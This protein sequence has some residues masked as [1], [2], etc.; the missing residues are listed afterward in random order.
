MIRRPPRSTLFPYTTLFRSPPPKAARPFASLKRRKAL[1]CSNRSKGR[2]RLDVKAIL[3]ALVLG[4]PL[5][6]RIRAPRRAR[7]LA[8]MSF[9]RTTLREE[10]VSRCRT[11]PLSP[12]PSRRPVD[13]RGLAD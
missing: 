13:L 3:L 7:E 9:Y 8:P 4:T 12:L 1:W 6:L 5:L 10:A 2:G 11:R